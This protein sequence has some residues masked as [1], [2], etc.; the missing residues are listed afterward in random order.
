MFGMVL[1]AGAPAQLKVMTS[2][3]TVFKN[4]PNHLND[5]NTTTN[6]LAMW[7]LMLKDGSGNPVF[8]AG[9]VEKFANQEPKLA[10]C[11]KWPPATEAIFTLKS[12][13]CFTRQGC[14]SEPCADF[15]Q[16]EES[17]WPARPC[18]G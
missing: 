13:A 9:F 12:S 16:G 6:H 4:L 5:I 3:V 7:G 17:L 8:V 11:E 14:H 15:A 18:G 10:R 2:D 1:G